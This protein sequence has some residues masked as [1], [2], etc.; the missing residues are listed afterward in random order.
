METGEYD[1]SEAAYLQALEVLDETEWGDT[2]PETFIMETPIG[3]E[4]YQADRYDEGV[5]HQND[6]LE[7]PERTL[8]AT[9]AALMEQFNEQD[10]RVLKAAERIAMLPSR[11]P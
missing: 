4:L 9:H 7:R 8:E 10:E 6:V 2:H 5:L 11:A 3:S 1:D